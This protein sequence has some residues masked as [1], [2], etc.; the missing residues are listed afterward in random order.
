MAASASCSSM[1]AVWWLVRCY[2]SVS[3]FCISGLLATIILAVEV[4]IPN[5]SVE[6]LHDLS[7]WSSRGPPNVLSYQ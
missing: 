5:L 7:D 3:C 1:Y 6:E 2:A 4:L